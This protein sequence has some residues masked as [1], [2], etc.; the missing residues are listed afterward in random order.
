MVGTTAYPSLQEA[1]TAAAEGATVTLLTDV[2]MGGALTVASGKDITLDLN[3][4][5]LN[6]TWVDGWDADW[7]NSLAQNSTI[8]NQ[9][10]LTVKDRKADSETG[11][12]TG[13]ILGGNDTESSDDWTASGSL[14]IAVYN[15]TGA[16]F[17]L[18]SGIIARDDDGSFGNY[19]IR[20][21]GTMTIN[22]GKV[23][24]GSTSSSLINNLGT[25]EINGGEFTNGRIVLRNEDA[26]T[27]TINGGT[28]TST[29]YTM[30]CKLNGTVFINGGIINQ[31]IGVV[32][33]ETDDDGN[34]T[35]V[36]GSVTINGGT[37]QNV[38]TSAIYFFSGCDGS[39]TIT[40]NAQIDSATLVSGEDGTT[41]NSLTI[42]GGL[43]STMP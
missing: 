22:N 14:G 20:N 25:M 12:G 43:Y 1:V 42:T 38:D 35:D 21:Y 31:G 11:I 6:R 7:N 30:S 2:T 39:V 34:K 27:L 28:F 16:E 33:R 9:G 24:N 13:K 18:N 36:V 29:S 8:Y 23:V 4:H 26:S 32:G 41:P 5:I 37:I 40:G 10:K 19:T 17:T 15:E 3:G